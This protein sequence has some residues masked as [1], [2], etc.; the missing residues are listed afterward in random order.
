[1]AIRRSL[2]GTGTEM[3]LEKISWLGNTSTATQFHPSIHPRS[4]NSTWAASNL[5]NNGNKTGGS[6]DRCRVE[7]ILAA[8]G[9]HDNAAAVG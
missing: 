8:C 1:M 5:S 9:F 7:D 6:M 3:S 4:V 2:G